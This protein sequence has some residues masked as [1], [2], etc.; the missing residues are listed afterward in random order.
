MSNTMMQFGSCP[1][2]QQVIPNDRLYSRPLI[3]PSCGF[4]ENLHE[5]TLQI[6]QEKKFIKIALAVTA[7]LIVAFYQSVH[8]DVYAFEI[9]PLKIKQL[10]GV[11][12]ARDLDR[13]AEICIERKKHECVED[14]YASKARIYRDTEALSLL[15]QYQVKREKWQEAANTFRSYFNQGGLDLEASYQFAKSLGK[16]GQV[17]DSVRYFDQVLQAKPETLQITVVQNYV[18]MLMDNGRKD[19]ALQVIE[20]TRKSSPTANSFMQA[21]FS[22]LQSQRFNRR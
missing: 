12:S 4:T 15:G 11:V 9:L 2:C 10:S 1:R 7:F 22:E 19:Q 16:V 20:E 17:E 13:I 3:C 18:K 6:G 21:E 14:A 8:W 5:S